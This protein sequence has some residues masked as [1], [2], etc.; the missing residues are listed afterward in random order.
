MSDA[1]GSTAP[2]SLFKQR[3]VCGGR[4]QHYKVIPVDA[5]AVELPRMRTAVVQDAMQSLKMSHQLANDSNG[6]IVFTC[7]NDSMIP[8]FC[9][10]LVSPDCEMPH[11]PVDSI[12]GLINGEISV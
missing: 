1:S 11:L 3:A 12:L 5:V 8:D 2:G 6:L 7:S 4:V 10:P 9:M